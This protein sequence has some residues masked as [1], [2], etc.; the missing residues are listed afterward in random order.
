MTDNSND[1]RAPR[2][3]REARG[4]RAPRGP[5]NGHGTGDARAVMSCRGWNLLDTPVAGT[6]RRILRD[7][8]GRVLAGDTQPWTLPA[9]GLPSDMPW[10]QPIP[11]DRNFVDAEFL[12]ESE[13]RAPALGRPALATAVQRPLV[14]G[15][16]TENRREQLTSPGSAVRTGRQSTRSQPAIRRKAWRRLWN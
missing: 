11:Q 2:D 7:W 6:L 14:H 3:A 4:Q 15:L 16:G 13:G 10:T 1:S 5:R 8:D 9:G 12:F